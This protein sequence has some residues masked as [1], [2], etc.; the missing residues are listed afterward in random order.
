M[1][2]DGPTRDGAGRGRE[3]PELARL[4]TYRRH[5][6][7]A[8]VA[9]LGLEIGVYEALAG[10]P[11]R[12]GELAES[13][14][15]DERGLD[16]LLGALEELGAVRHDEDGWRLTGPGRARFVDQDTPDHQA[17]AASL[18][19][20][21]TRRLLEQLP[22]AV[23]TGEPARSAGTGG[24]GDGDVARFQAAMA[25]KDPEMVER[26]ARACAGACVERMG[27]GGAGG[28]RAL[29]LGG[30]PGVFARA[31][32]DR[33]FE[34]TLFDRPEVVEHVSDAYGLAG[35]AGIELRAGDFTDSLPE[36]PFDLVLLANITHLLRP[37][38]NA[39]LLSRLSDRMTEGGLLAVVDFVRGASSFAPLFGITMLL[40]TAE[41]N[42]YRRSDYERW[43][44][45][46]G[47]GDVRLRAV[48]EDRHLITA[49]LP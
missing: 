44:A 4:R 9:A 49:R 41:G 10:G 14:S 48:D 20:S 25:D 33:G 21:N 23:R 5:A 7:W 34:V 38:D 27:D 29:D 37:E 28:R 30:G 15:A 3:G 40:N 12:L 16:V 39:S 2:A 32:R 45:D 46:A 31:L 13:L 47:F 22:E 43:L 8:T 26:V 24:S 35:A 19:L 11:L 1:T 42:T 17:G 36:G 18:W 6:D